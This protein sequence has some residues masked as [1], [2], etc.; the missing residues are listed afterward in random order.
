M[1]FLYKDIFLAVFP[2]G[3]EVGLEVAAAGTGN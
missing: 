2:R 1:I 3:T